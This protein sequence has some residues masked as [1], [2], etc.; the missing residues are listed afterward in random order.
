MKKNNVCHVL[1]YQQFQNETVESLRGLLD[2]NYKIEVC[3]VLKNN[4]VELVAMIIKREEDYITPNIYLENYYQQYLNGTSVN[5]IIEN[6]IDSHFEFL[7]KGMREINQVNYEWP[8]VKDGIFYRIINRD[9]NKKL[10]ETVPHIL[11]LDLAITFQYLASDNKDG[12]GMIRI[13][14]EHMEEWG[15]NLKDLKDIATHNTPCLFPPT[16]RNMNEVIYDM[17]KKDWADSSTSNQLY[18]PKSNLNKDM[19]MD[20]LFNYEK[21]E[22]PMYV[23]SNSHGI[24][25]AACIL[26]KDVLLQLAYELDSDLL[27]LPSS[28]HEV[29]AIKDDGIIN[30]ADIVD[31]VAEVNEHEVEDEDYLSNQVYQY[32]RSSDVIVM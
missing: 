26:Y 27:I 31:M 15:I 3:K 32:N 11:Y 8:N 10:L 29:I 12:I 1:T 25:G 30:K 28:I 18:D 4:S 19:L 20:I 24:N 2:D 16:V 6:I 23:L 21:D 22:S 7:E 14:K 5:E 13:T 9:K 17:I